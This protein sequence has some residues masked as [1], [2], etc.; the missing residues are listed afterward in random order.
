VGMALSC[1]LYLS[2]LSFVLAIIF[3]M[4]ARIIAD[5]NNASEKL[6][7][8]F[9][10]AS[11]VALFTALSLSVSMYGVYC[12]HIVYLYVGNIAVVLAVLPGGILLV[13]TVCWFCYVV[14]WYHWPEEVMDL[15]NEINETMEMKDKVS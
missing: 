6:A 9:I 5:S 12:A 2:I 11:V 4:M 7:R 13:T 10:F 8:R 1:V 3:A 15:I 14:Y